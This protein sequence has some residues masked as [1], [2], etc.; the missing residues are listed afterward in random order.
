MMKR[1]CVSM[2]VCV[3][4]AGFPAWGMDCGAADSLWTEDGKRIPVV[5]EDSVPQGYIDRLDYYY[6]SCTPQI[7]LDDA[8]INEDYG[9]AP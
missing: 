2:G 8:L 3:W 4:L 5:L 6:K 1:W 7:E 9:Y